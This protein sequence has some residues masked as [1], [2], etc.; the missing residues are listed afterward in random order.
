MNRHIHAFDR[1]NT[2]FKFPL[3]LFWGTETE[4]PIGLIEYF[5]FTFGFS[6]AGKCRGHGFFQPD[7]HFGQI[8]YSLYF[9]LISMI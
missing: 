9:L 3:L 5:L 1:A 7:G 6:L 2:T 4:L 8:T